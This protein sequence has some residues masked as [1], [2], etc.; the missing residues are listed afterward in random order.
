[1]KTFLQTLFFLLLVTQI[2]FAQWYQQT[3][4]TTRDLNGLAFYDLNNGIAVGD[5]GIILSTTNGGTTWTLQSSVTNTNLYAVSYISANWV[6]VGSDGT[7]IH[8]GSLQAS[9][10]TNTLHD[11]CFTD[12]TNGC[13]VGSGSLSDGIILRT[14][15]GGTF[16]S[17]QI[18][19]LIEC[20]YGI[21][22][23]DVN[24]GIA[25][26]GEY[27]MYT[28]GRILRTTDGGLTWRID[29]M[30]VSLLTAV[31]FGDN[32]NGFTISNFTG[33]SHLGSPS[34]IIRTID[35]GIT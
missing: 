21:S 1:M 8:N 13:V 15:D 9:G 11:V 3:S 16:W 10:T 18:S 12:A 31:S 2:C 26:G 17:V 5:S 4:G 33:N 23:A 22:F 30:N 20:L 34:S 24:N 29:T 6:A 27:G 32:T 14:T 28:M 25:V 7:I 35:A 19:G